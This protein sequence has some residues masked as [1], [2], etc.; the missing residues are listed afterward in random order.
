MSS[1]EEINLCL[2]D[3]TLDGI[4]KCNTGLGDICIAYKIP[5]DKINECNFNELQY[6]GVYILFDEAGHKAYIGQ[7][8]ENPLITRLKQQKH[9]K[10]WW[11]EAI[12]F[13]SS[14]KEFIGPTESHYLEN[15]L[16]DIAKE[17]HPEILDNDQIPGQGTTARRGTKIQ[18]DKFVDYIKLITK[19]LGYNIFISDINNNL[20][21][22][23]LFF[24]YIGNKTDNKKAIIERTNWGYKLYKGSY[25]EEI[26]E[27]LAD[28]YKAIRSQYKFLIEADGILKENI[29]FLKPSPAASFALGRNSNGNE[30]KNINKLP[31]N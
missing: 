31:L 2:F 1:M 4:V 5:K 30:F 3:G 16:Y 28:S 14:N 23:K 21:P 6:L 19:V 12:A 29:P 13:T 9:D 18:L 11:T 26:N 22:D 20:I 10:K 25:I 7:T 8:N 15:K 24:H 27:N 17:A